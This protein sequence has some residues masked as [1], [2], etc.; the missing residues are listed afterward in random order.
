MV[1]LVY[2]YIRFSSKKQQKG[3]SFR[4]QVELGEK[5]IARNADKGYVAANLTL[6]DIGVSAFRG[7]NKHEGA[8]KRFLEEVEAGRVKPGSILL[9]EHLDRLSREGVTQAYSLFTQILNAGVQIAVLKP[10]E[11]L[12]TSKSVNDLVGL[13][14]PLIYF[15]LAHLESKTKSDRLRKVWDHKREDAP[16]GKVFDR[17]RPCWIDWDEEAKRFVLNEGAK[18]IRFIFERTAEGWGQRRVLKGL[19]QGFKPIGTSGRWNSSFIQK[20]LNDRAVLGERQPRT[21]D[22]N[23]RRMPVGDPIPNYYPAVVDQVLWHRAHA[24]KE[25]RKKQKGPSRQFINLF[26]SLLVN[27]HDRHPMHIQTTRLAGGGVQRRLVSYGHDEKLPDSDPTSVPYYDFERVVL[28]FLNELRPE[29]VEPRNRGSDVTLKEQELSGVQLRL[30]ELEEEMSDPSK[31][32]VK[33][34]VAAAARLEKRRD[35]LLEEIERLKQEMHS[36]RPLNEAKS[37]LCLLDEAEPEQQE[38]LRLRL[39]CLIAEFVESI[40]IKPEKHFGRVYFLAQINFRNGQFKQVNYGPGFFGGFREQTC[41]S[42]FALDL[43]D[44]DA[45]RS[46]QVFAQIAAMLAQPSLDPIPEGVPQTVEEAAE[47]WLKIARRNMAK[48]SF[49][50]VPAKVRRFVKFIGPTLAPT[51]VGP[52]CWLE[53]VGWLQAEVAA[54]RMARATARITYSRSREFVRW[55][56]EK[57]ALADIAELKVSADSAVGPKDEG[58]RKEGAA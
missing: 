46:K 57:C 38:A 42:D 43:R 56:I 41:P 52:N 17:R 18:A 34:A 29:D 53:W 32:P 35:E 7:K 51:E 20:V 40:H 6:H 5:W 55:L 8:L 31:P 11:Q 3:D 21:F 30:T 4:R 48:Q 1:V 54:G 22:D 13:L 24:S 12:Y 19:V 45:A 49:R 37:I 9:V 23:G 33:T 14:L 44:R 58:Q 2:S 15:Y 27:A 28:W 26:T 39:R 50:V 47:V 16:G 10:H 36:T 25:R